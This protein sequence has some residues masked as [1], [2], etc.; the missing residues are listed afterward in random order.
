[1]R[2]YRN[3][4]RQIPAKRELPARPEVV[5]EALR[6]M[7]ATGRQKRLERVLDGRIHSVIPVLD[8][9]ADPFNISA[10]L[11][12]CDA[13]GIHEVNVIENRVGFATASRVAQGSEQW[14]N[15]VTHDSHRTCH[16]TL[17]ARGYSIYVATAEGEYTPESLRD[18]EKLA[19]VF[20]NEHSGVS[21]ELRDL[22]DGTFAIPMRGFTDSLN[23]SV[24]AAVSLHVVSNGRSSEL[25]AESR[26]EL[27][28]R[29]MLLA[30]RHSEEIVTE[31]LRRSIHSD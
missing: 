22:A 6:P 16:S 29:Y 11:R 26:A 17:K 1:M 25:D 7:I 9:L 5:I 8:Q 10:V 18:K 21:D 19:L 4:L 27:L 31:H 23:V 28:A 14:L 15:I 24:A 30:V 20:G 3:K 13:L 12:S 2:F